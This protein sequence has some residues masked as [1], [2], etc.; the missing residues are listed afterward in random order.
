MHC[1][2][3]SFFSSRPTLDTRFSS[4]TLRR[5][6]TPDRDNNTLVPLT[7][8]SVSLPPSYSCSGLFCFLSHTKSHYIRPQFLFARTLC[9]RSY[10]VIR[11]CVCGELLGFWKVCASISAKERFGGRTAEWDRIPNIVRAQ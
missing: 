6:R 8:L 11:L 9:A 2:T 3:L 7:T 4:S 5:T 10:S 1:D